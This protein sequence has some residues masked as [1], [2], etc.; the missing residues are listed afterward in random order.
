M[1]NANA[2]I[3]VLHC[4]GLRKGCSIGIELETKVT[5]IDQDQEVTNDHH[6]LLGAI[7]DCW[8]SRGLPSPSELGW[9]VESE[10]PIGQGLKSSSAVAC[11][12]LRALNSCSFAGISDDEI[13]DL[14][15]SAQ[16]MAKCSITGSLDDVLASMGPGWKLIDPSQKS[17]KS[18]I[19]EGKLDSNLSVIICLRGKR[20]L[21]ISPESFSQESF[22]FERALDSIL[23]GSPLEAISSNGLAV[24]A[25]TKD[26]EAMRISNLSI[27]SGAISSGISGSG[28]SIAV[29]CFEDDADEISSNLSNLGLDVIKTKFSRSEAILEGHF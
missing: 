24:A 11:A 14:A 17:S 25:S 27:A 22:L 6:N 2:A 15:V 3:S 26:Y 23:Q 16:K 7:L 9:R 28:P 29:I 8:R 19:M 4:L 1:G 12:A 20:K 21:Q 5:I 10:I 13:A 18:I